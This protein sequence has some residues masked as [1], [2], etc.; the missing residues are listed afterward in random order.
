MPEKLNLS[1]LQSYL[2]AAKAGPF[3]L[4]GHEKRAWRSHV[5]AADALWSL[6]AEVYLTDE[7][8]TALVSEMPE[9]SYLVKIRR[10]CSVEVSSFATSTATTAP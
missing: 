2:W 6:R 5:T 3:P 4:T 1:F 7:A 8:M 9:P 10:I